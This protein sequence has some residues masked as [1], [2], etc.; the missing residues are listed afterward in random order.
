MRV[1]LTKAD[2]TVRVTAGGERERERERV[3]VR[4]CARRRLIRAGVPAHVSF[5]PHN[6]HAGCVRAPLSH[7]PSYLPCLGAI[8]LELE[9]LKHQQ[10]TCVCVCARL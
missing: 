2:E 1:G 5:H 3:R 9:A 6:Q 8:S 10:D 7:R 4:A